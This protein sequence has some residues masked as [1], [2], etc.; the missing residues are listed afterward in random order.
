MKSILFGLDGWVRTAASRASNE[1]GTEHGCGANGKEKNR[2][3]V[4]GSG[5]IDFGGGR[6]VFITNEVWMMM[7][8][9]PVAAI[10][11]PG[12][13]TD[14]TCCYYNAQSLSFTQRY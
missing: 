7:I 8:G 3:H 14:T 9:S 11:W 12:C 5:G 10:S 2:T 6:I 4:G 1:G 13:S